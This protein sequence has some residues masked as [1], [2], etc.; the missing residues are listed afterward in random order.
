MEV[1][2]PALAYGKQW[3]SPEEYLQLE[4]AAQERHEYYRGEVF[5]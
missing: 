1:H 4:A 3:L 5:T 2:E